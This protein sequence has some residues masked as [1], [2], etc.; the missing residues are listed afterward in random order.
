MLVNPLLDFFNFSY[1]STVSN[2]WT[3]LLFSAFSAFVGLPQI[4]LIV[5][6]LIMVRRYKEI[7]KGTKI[8]NKKPYNHKFSETINEI[9]QLIPL[10]K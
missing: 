4:V 3:C 5:I 10:T 1:S 2:R 8:M 6:V 9:F 7:I